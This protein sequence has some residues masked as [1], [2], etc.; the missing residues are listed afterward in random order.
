MRSLVNSLAD[1][2]RPL[3][4]AIAR[5]YGV[6]REA[7]EDR[8]TLAQRLAAE[9][10]SP[11]GWAETGRLCSKG[12]WAALLTLQHHSGRMPEVLFS[13]QYG[14][15]RP[16]G[17]AQLWRVRP[18]QAPISIAEELLYRGLIF[19]GFAPQAGHLTAFIY[20]PVELLA[21]LPPPVAEDVALLSIVA[22]ESSFWAADAF[23]L[24]LVA[25]LVFMQQNGKI[26][27]TEGG[28]R[29]G[30][31]ELA[32]LNRRLQAPLPPDRLNG[33]RLSLRLSLLFYILH[34][35]RLWRRS[36]GEWRLGKGKVLLS[37]L[38]KDSTVQHW[39]I[40]R[41]WRDGRWNDLCHVPWLT[42]PDKQ[43]PLNIA[44]SRYRFLRQLA[45]WDSRGWHRLG[46]VLALFAEHA[47]DFLRPD[48]DFETPLARRAIDGKWLR[49]VGSWPEVEGNLL[50]FFFLGPMAW[51]G[52]V[53]LSQPLPG[54]LAMVSP[55]TTDDLLW[56]LSPW[57]REWLTGEILPGGAAI[58]PQ[59][60][61]D[62]QGE[63]T[64]LPGATA[65]THFRV[66]RFSRWLASVPT[67]RYRITEDQIQR[68][69]RQGL[70]AS[71]IS[72]FL[73]AASNDHVPVSIQQMLKGVS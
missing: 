3:L 38:K 56:Q 11:E 59:L 26:G 71:Q 12:A 45:A 10:T 42:C 13:R 61:I 14:I 4:E 73:I 33:E 43:R 63:I 8:F 44:A 55:T 15:I 67:F 6:D 70:S 64:L 48:A 58:A 32:D 66:G 49:G 39:S 2:P 51:L 34:R 22:P 19:R 65:R 24:D 9:I 60:Q 37:W 29:P 23:W 31:G 25:L 46:D 69:R 20:V 72:G 54:C 50:R 30:I 28:H 62:E 1:H 21:L 47:A 5:L 68:A 35:L 16:L 36:D 53:R 17:E 40:W 57:G 18:W 27:L 41:A 52:A 7:G